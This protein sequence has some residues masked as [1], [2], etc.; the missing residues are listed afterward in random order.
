MTFHH[1]RDT[2]RHVPCASSFTTME[3][4]QAQSFPA[5]LYDSETPRKKSAD[6]RVFQLLITVPP[7][8]RKMPALRSELVDAKRSPVCS[9]TAATQ[10]EAVSAQRYL[11]SELSTG[12]LSALHSLSFLK[13]LSALRTIV[14]PR[15]LP[16]F[17]GGRT[18]ISRYPTEREVF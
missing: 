12:M 5:R 1:P 15:S 10:A 14:P 17:L 11:H 18:P 3:S 16:G 4:A 13:L 2:L 7:L 6:T 9:Q 8:S